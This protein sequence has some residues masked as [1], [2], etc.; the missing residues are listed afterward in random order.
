MQEKVETLGD[1]VFIH[2]NRL[3][4]FGTDA[5]LLADFSG[6]RVGEKSADLCSGCGIVAL[7]WHRVPGC[8]PERTYCVELQAQAAELLRRSVAASGLTG[9]VI[10]IEKDLRALD[11]RDIPLGSLDLCACN[12]PYKA[13]GHG[14]LNP[15]EG[16]A[17]ARHGL[18][19][20][21]EDICRT[22]ARLLRYGGRFCLCQRP[23][24]LCDVF[25]ALRASGMEPKRLRL[26][27][28]RPDTAPWLALVEGRRGSKPFLK[29][30]PPLIVQN[31]EGGFSSE[32]RRIYR[33][34]G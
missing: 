29:V 2:V 28:K 17:L 30:E 16:K 6:A 19:G 8:R 7:L 31:E 1:G 13:A 4:R 9:K 24:R 32:M 33:L 23:E 12:P 3:H 22:A 34:Q 10:P 18:D 26:V 27:Q 14:L 20:S 11:G 21:L 25:T 15:E 5:F